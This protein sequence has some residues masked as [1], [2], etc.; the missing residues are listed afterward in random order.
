MEKFITKES[1]NLHNR[2]FEFSDIQRLK[3]YQLQLISLVIYNPPRFKNCNQLNSAQL[4]R[5]HNEIKNI[6]LYLKKAT[7][8]F[9]NNNNRKFQY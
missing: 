5:I 4:T 3:N 6:E 1:R 8:D 7:A 9:I 2:I